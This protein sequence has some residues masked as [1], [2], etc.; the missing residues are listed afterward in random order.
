MNLHRFETLDPQLLPG[1]VNTALR[2]DCEDLED[3][4]RTHDLDKDSFLRR[5]DELGYRYS[6]ATHQF[7]PIAVDSTGESGQKKNPSS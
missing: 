3:L 7:R 2:N 4:V 5:M 6:T 1:L